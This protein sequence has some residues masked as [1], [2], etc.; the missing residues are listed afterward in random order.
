MRAPLS[1]SILCLTRN[2]NTVLSQCSTLSHPGWD[3]IS[4]HCDR[5]LQ[6]RRTTEELVSH[7]KKGWPGYGN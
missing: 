2:T 1:N 6:C 3:Y 5:V 4:A 7:G